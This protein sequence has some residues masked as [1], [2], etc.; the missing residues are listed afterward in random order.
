MRYRLK[1]AA[2]DTRVEI[3]DEAV[4]EAEKR[5]ADAK[6][7]DFYFRFQNGRPVLNV[8]DAGN[9]DLKERRLKRESLAPDES[10]L[11]QRKDPDQYPELSW[12]AK[13]FGRIQTFR[14]WSFGR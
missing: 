11:S 9:G 6:D 5:R 3:V 14:E 1:F 13:S 4:E 8:R 12:C 7:V 2:V 10:V